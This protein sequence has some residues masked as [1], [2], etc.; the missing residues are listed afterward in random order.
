MNP[1]SKPKIFFAI[2]CGGFYSIQATII[3]KICKEYDVHYEIDEDDPTTRIL[4]TE[5]QDKIINCDYFI[6]DVSYKNPNILMELGFAIKDKKLN[7]VCIFKSKASDDIS[8]ISGIVYCEFNSFQVFADKLSKWLAHK[9]GRSLIDSK[10]IASEPAAYDEDFLSKPRFEKYWYVPPGSQHIF[11]DGIKFNSVSGLPFLTKHLGLLGINYDVTYELKILKN[12]IGLVVLGVIL[13]DA[14]YPS[15][16]SMIQLHDDGKVVPHVFNEATWRVGRSRG[17]AIIPRNKWTSI[18]LEV[19]KFK[20][21][22]YDL[23][24]ADREEIDFENE[25]LNVDFQ[26]EENNMGQVGFRCAYYGDSED[27]LYEEANVK[28]LSVNEII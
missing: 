14:F 3:K 28:S 7:D 4:W 18:R 24:S 2:P 25:F 27:R 13:P 19:R 21:T 16:F 22:L 17:S 6:A 5:I 11:K 9:L 12:R 10:S 23:I 26:R 1:K 15:F 20:I 8:D